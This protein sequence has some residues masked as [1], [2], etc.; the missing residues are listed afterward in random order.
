MPRFAHQTESSCFKQNSS[1]LRMSYISKSPSGRNITDIN[2]KSPNRTTAFVTNSRTS[3]QPQISTRNGSKSPAGTNKTCGFSFNSTVGHSSKGEDSGRQQADHI[4]KLRNLKYNVE[5]KKSIMLDSFN[6][7]TV[8]SFIDLERIKRPSSIALSTGKLVCR[9]FSIFK[10]TGKLLQPNFIEA[11]TSDWVHMQ[12]YI[13][14][15]VTMQSSTDFFNNIRTKVLQI[16]NMK[17]EKREAF[18]TIILQIK[19]DFFSGDNIKQFKHIETSKNLSTIVHFILK[20]VHYIFEHYL[21]EKHI[22]FQAP[23]Q[24]EGEDSDRFSNDLAKSSSFE[25][26]TIT[27]K[28]QVQSTLNS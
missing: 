28:I 26:L 3:E 20:V 22:R 15:F 8:Q 10:D 24:L 17:I 23:Q 13:H 7:M 18:Q 6:I 27:R 11:L 14:G 2:F 1:V 16:P 5:V 19:K 9:F 25:A 12:K 21:L 4:Q